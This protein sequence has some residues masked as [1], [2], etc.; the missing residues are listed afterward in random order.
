MFSLLSGLYTTY[1]KP[2]PLT[3]LIVGLDASG[4]TVLMEA[5]KQSYKTT[6]VI[7]P[8]EKIKPT[9]GVNCA[10]M[11]LNSTHLTLYDA[12]G[13]ILSRPLWSHYYSDCDGIIYVVDRSDVAR[14]EE[15]VLVY[16]SVVKGVYER[17]RRTNRVKSNDG[18]NRNSGSSS[19]RISTAGAA[20]IPIAIFLNKSDST[21]P[22]QMSTVDIQ[23]TFPQDSRFACQIFEGSGKDALQ[24]DADGVASVKLLLEWVVG[25]CKKT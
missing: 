14:L 19:S 25:E 11:T 8:V 23:D 17:L 3:I 5:I 18:A 10:T 9:I 12:A 15:I 21:Q 16:E 7:I 4:K 2:R 20:R 22:S 24:G 6:S 1:I 13:S